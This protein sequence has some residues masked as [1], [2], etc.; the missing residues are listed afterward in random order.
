MPDP[1]PCPFCG[2]TQI[3]SYGVNS[4]GFWQWECRGCGARGPEEDTDKR[5]RNQWDQRVP[6]CDSEED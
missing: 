4:L 1:K 6:L 5:A 2:H 3:Q